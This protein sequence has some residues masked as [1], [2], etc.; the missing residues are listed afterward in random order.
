M[1]TEN[2]IPKD[3]VIR[4]SRKNIRSDL[5]KQLLKLSHNKSL[6]NQYENN[7]KKKFKTIFPTWD[8]RVRK[9]VNIIKNCITKK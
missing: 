9:E 4:I 8:D 1:S 2:I 6:I 5:K 7:I 3:F